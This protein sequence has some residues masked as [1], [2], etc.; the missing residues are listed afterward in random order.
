MINSNPVFY[1]EDIELLPAYSDIESLSEVSLTTLLDG[2]QLDIPIIASPTDVAVTVDWITKRGGMGIIHHRNTTLDEQVELMRRTDRRAAS[3]DVERSGA[4]DRVEA[5][6][7]AGASFI[8][9]EAQRGHSKVA[10]DFMMRLSDTYADV[11]VMSPPICTPDA[12]HWAIDNGAHVL[13]VT[14][15]SV[16]QFTA[17]CEIAEE[18]WTESVSLVA[19]SVVSN[20]KDAVKALC[21][22]ADALMLDRR[23]V[24]A[25][26][27]DDFLSGIRSGFADIGAR[28]IA[29]ARHRASFRSTK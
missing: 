26:R 7:D 22:G 5:L 13:R 11:T 25:D 12:A 1:Y 14:G 28:N 21:A 27:L 29:E 24:S 4:W 10:G 15:G 23:V 6:V 2:T 9:V 18:V 19:D 20:G 3:V 8:G 17:L 16:P